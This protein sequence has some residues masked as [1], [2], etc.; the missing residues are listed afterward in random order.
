MMAPTF[1]FSGVVGN[2]RVKKGL[3]AALVSPD[4]TGVLIRGGPGTA[5]TTLVRGMAGLVPGVDIVNLP[6]NVTEEQMTG[7]LDLEGALTQGEVRYLPGLLRRAQ[8]HIL[9]A[10]EINLLPEKMV[11]LMTQSCDVGDGPEGNPREARS[12]L[13]IGTM[14]PD[15][16]ELSSHLMDRFDMVLDVTETNDAEI[17]KEILRRVLE[18]SLERSVSIDRFSSEEDRLRQRISEA[19]DLLKYVTLAPGHIETIAQLAR[20]L[21]IEGSR[22]GIAVARTAKALAALEGREEVILDDV[23]MAATLCLAHR[24]RIDRD[25]GEEEPVAEDSPASR[26]VDREQTQTTAGES[27]GMEVTG[28]SAPDRVIP[29]GTGPD[30][31]DIFVPGRTTAR[32]IHSQEGKRG[33]VI[34]D[35]RRGRYI[36]SRMPTGRPQDL[37]LDATLRAAAPFQGSRERGELAVS[38]LPSDLREKVRM[39]KS[40]STIIFLVDASGSMGVK[41][42]MATVKGTVLTILTDA[43]RKRDSVGLVIFHRNTADVLL[44]PTRSV[45]AAYKKLREIP[46]GGR[47]PLALGLIKANDLLCSCRPLGKRQERSLVVISDG[48]ANVPLAGGDP[49][50]EALDIAREIS[51]TTVRTV[52]VDTG[53]GMPRIDRGERLARALG[54]SYLRL[55]EMSSAQLARTIRASAET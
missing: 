39:S 10:D 48:R 19:R 29:I 26:P 45:H 8:G 24:R 54:G 5:K 52:V 16:G 49:F 7:S 43:Y 12:F 9:Y 32:P 47:T 23:K 53:T 20:D 13:L 27:G 38:I 46:T 3:L 22:G 44:Q 37:A 31:A 42:R 1:P 11:H 17:R 4:V 21:G 30:L 6:L 41:E 35:R 25:Q 55:E 51:R 36:A 34:S 40:G 2:E 15:E 14:D 28:P 50:N 33:R 18:F